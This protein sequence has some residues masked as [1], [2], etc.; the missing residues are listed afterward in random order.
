MCHET[1]KRSKINY[2][3][4]KVSTYFCQGESGVREAAPIKCGL[5][6]RARGRPRRRLL[7]CIGSMHEY[8]RWQ[9]YCV[10]LRCPSLSSGTLYCCCRGARGGGGLLLLLSQNAAGLV[11]MWEGRRG[12]FK[13]FSCT[14]GDQIA[15]SPPLWSS[16]IPW[17]TCQ[18]GDVLFWSPVGG[19]RN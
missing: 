1:G 6:S 2:H 7:W 8:T 17:E 3:Y 13:V 16:Y 11:L 4:K 15:L 19:G 5:S 12:K 9:P 14:R 10:L 18:T